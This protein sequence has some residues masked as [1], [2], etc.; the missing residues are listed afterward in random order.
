MATLKGLAALNDN[1]RN[2]DWES[3][4]SDGY[5][6]AI[7]GALNLYAREP[8]ASTAAWIDSEITVMWSMQ[9]SSHRSNTSQWRSSGIIEGC[10]H[11]LG[12]ALY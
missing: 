7:E 3:G 1:Y 4:S 8:L 12:I 5:A 2:F 6:D 10:N 11:W 9:D